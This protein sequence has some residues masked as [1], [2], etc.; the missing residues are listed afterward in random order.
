MVLLLACFLGTASIPSSFSQTVPPAVTLKQ[1]EAYYIKLVGPKPGLALR[2]R[3]G[4][5]TFPF[6]PA[7]GGLYGALIGIDMAEEPSR[8]DLVVEGLGEASSYVLEVLPASF[9]L[10]EL[11]LPKGQVELD[12][13]TLKRVQREQDEI[14]RSMAPTTPEK[15][16][17]GP[18]VF[19]VEGKPTRNFGMRRMMNGEPRSP[20]TGEDFTAPAGT[21]VWA[22]NAG[23]VVLLGDY[24]FSGK[25][26]ILNHGQGCYTMYFHLN[27]TAV[28]PGDRV[29]KG[30][31]IG[32]VGSTG[33]ASGPHLH[34]GARING[35]R[36][37]PLSLVGLKESV[38]SGAVE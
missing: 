9:G 16:W 14:V 34:W 35:A 26:V 18:F 8:Y 13:E 12:A 21:P 25:S 29:R 28:K 1:G 37:D 2:L 24:F 27:D 15:L 22:S 19:P 10:Q 38:V 30:D 36:V 20:H 4:D 7:D 6:H 31:R 5:R 33:R 17:E 11:T 32:S 3:W 23:R